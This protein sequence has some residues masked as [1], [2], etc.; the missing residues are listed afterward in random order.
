MSKSIVLSWPH[1]LGTAEAH[2]RIAEGLSNLRQSFAGK[3]TSDVKWTGDHADIHVGALGQFVNAKLDVEPASV[4]IEVQ[5]PWL[6]AALANRIEPYLQKFG[7]DMLRL[8]GPPK[9]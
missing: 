8:G 3:M 4:R 9:K 2:R 1:D 6:L 5:L 7:A